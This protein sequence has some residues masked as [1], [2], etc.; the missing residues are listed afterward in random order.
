RTNRGR[1]R[2]WGEKSRLGYEASENIGDDE[3]PRDG[4]DVPLPEPAIQLSA[5]STHTCAVTQSHRV[6]CWGGNG[7]GGSG[8]VTQGGNTP[9]TEYVDIGDDVASVASGTNST[10]AILANGAVRCWGG[11]YYGQLGIASTEPIGDDEP[12]ASA[13]L[14]DLPG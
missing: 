4:E 5:S 6:I 13:P 3:F 11:N 10:C 8:G 1:V 12:I 9:P 2:C 7:F 14:V